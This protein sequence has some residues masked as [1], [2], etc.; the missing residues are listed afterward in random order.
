[1]AHYFTKP[2]RRQLHL[3]PVDMLE[4]VPDDDIVHL[5]L[6]IVDGMDLG[7]FES[8]YKTSGTGKSPYAPSMML[9]VLIYAYAHGYR[10]SRKIESLCTRD[11][12][13]RMI[14]GEHLPDH[15]TIA[16][17]RR[18]H[19]EDM[20]GVFTRVLK[21]CREAG[22]AKLGVM[23]L[24]GT[25]VKAN[26]SLDSN[27][28]LSTIEGEV[29]SILKAAEE[30]DKA[31]DALYGTRRGDELPH[32]LRNRAERLER[33][34]ECQARL[35]Q[36][37]SENSNKKTKKKKCS[38]G[39]K[40]EEAAEA[41]ANV[42]DPESRIMKAR[43]GWVQ[44]YNAQAA[45]TSDQ[46]IVDAEVCNEAN[47]MKQLEP[48]LASMWANL[49]LVEDE[50]PEL[51]IVVTDAGYCS[52]ANLELETDD[53]QLLIATRNGRKQRLVEQETPPPRGRIPAGLSAKEKMDR[54]LLTKKGRELM[55][56]R[57]QAPEPVFGQMKDRQGARQFS[58][59]G[60]EACDGEW[61]LDA[62]VHNLRKLH[63]KSVK[64]RKMKGKTIH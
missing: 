27:R 20:Q 41:K 62:L 13:F 40:T 11:A 8:R 58:M 18:R 50:D 14:V 23:L 36:E 43:G 22:L 39:R 46:I 32:G 30:A 26:A 28:T 60:L 25:K 51:G 16:R 5:I 7:R 38:C 44:G 53:C 24:D 21:L 63:S 52:E 4:W 17:F 29:S 42:T 10:S 33:L 12:G 64:S 45:V 57:G 61:K 55:V 37:A 56:L 1:M 2:D 48:M 47:D 19:M 3:L 59:R 49:S 6:D 34:Q 31:E 54:R 35:D 15:A 9:S